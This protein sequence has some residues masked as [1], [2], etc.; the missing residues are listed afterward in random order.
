MILFIMIVFAVIVMGI[1]SC[2][3][4]SKKADEEMDKMFEDYEREN[5]QYK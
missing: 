3:I 4:I 2:L 5:E 1:Y